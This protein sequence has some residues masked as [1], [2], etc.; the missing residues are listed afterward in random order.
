VTILAFPLLWII[1][2]LAGLWYSQERDIPWSIALMALPAFLL[3]ASFF[4][5]LGIDRLRARLE[6]LPHAALACV[7]VLAACLPY[8]A[9]SLAF[10][11]FAWRSLSIIAILSAAAS[12]WYVAL[13][14]RPLVDILFL[15][16]MAVVWLLKVLPPL[17]V[18][19]HPRL[20]LAVLGQLMWFRTGLYAMVSLR[21]AEGVGFGFWPGAREWKIG[22]LYFAGLLP[23]AAGLGWLLKFTHPSLRYDAWDKLT[24]V[25][26]GT[27]FGTLWVLALG[28]EFFFRGLLQQW[29]TTWLKNEWVALLVTSVLFGAV[30]LWYRGFPNWPFAALAAV[31]GV[32]YGLAFRQAHSIRASMVTHALTVT[33]W[34]LFFS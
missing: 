6:R 29:M 3:E 34:R 17:Y 23:V 13:P 21:R 19:P 16:A 12:F 2:T 8:A 27:F 1:G 4:Y 26:I 24:L 22:A 7:L 10:G 15:V 20:P 9:A 25:A 28:E 18:E 11:S 5:V 33:T 32:F 14:Q 30:H 31:A